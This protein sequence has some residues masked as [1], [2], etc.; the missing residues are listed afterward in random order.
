MSRWPVGKEIRGS[1]RTSRRGWLFGWWGENHHRRPRLVDGADKTLA[2][3]ASSAA[4][5]RV[6]S[7]DWRRS[8]GADRVLARMVALGS[9]IEV[10][11]GPEVGREGRTE[12]LGDNSGETSWNCW[13]LGPT[14]LRKPGSGDTGCEFVGGMGAVSIGGVGTGTGVGCRGDGVVS[15]TGTGT[16]GTHSSVWTEISLTSGLGGGS[17]LAEVRLPV[18]VQEILVRL[19]APQECLS[20]WPLRHTSVWGFQ[21][22]R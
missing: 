21:E 4:A 19:S 5:E 16:G 2:R 17:E 8:W 11:W 3:G 20:R 1:H 18:P 7:M 13:L 6:D 15:G 12:V 9:R 14:R 10:S 22:P